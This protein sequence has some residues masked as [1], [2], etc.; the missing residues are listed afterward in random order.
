[1]SFWHQ[2]SFCMIL[3]NGRYSFALV[4]TVFSL[5]EP[6]FPGPYCV[7]FA[8]SLCVYR[9]SGSFPQ[10]NERNYYYYHCYFKIYISSCNKIRSCPGYI[11]P[12]PQGRWPG[13]GSNKRATL[14]PAAAVLIE[15]QW[16][17]KWD[18]RNF[19]GLKAKLFWLKVPNSKN[20][21]LTSPLNCA[22][23]PIRQNHLLCSYQHNI[24]LTHYV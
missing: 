6:Q 4:I 12:L 20:L 19:I 21:R 11:L 14:S 10:S 9:Y 23:I 18:E 2:S 8:R 22:R 1:M 5:Q 7:E 17:I 3:D 24:P 15:N 13:K 16:A